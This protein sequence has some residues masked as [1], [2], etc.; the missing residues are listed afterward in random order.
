MKPCR[1]S[2][3]FFIVSS[4]TIAAAMLAIWLWVDQAWLGQAAN[5]ARKFLYLAGGLSASFL[6]ITWAVILLSKRMREEESTQTKFRTLLECVPDAL[7][8]MDREGHIVLVN[9]RTEEMFGYERAELLG[10]PA[11]TLVR[12]QVGNTS[13]ETSFSITSTQVRTS[14]PE[15]I[16]YHKDGKQIPLDMSFSPL[17]TEEGLLIINTVRDCSEQI[18]RDRRRATR[19]VIRRTLA[20]AANLA[21]A[22]PRLLEAMCENLEWD[23]GVLWSLDLESRQFRCVDCWQPLPRPDG[24]PQSP[25]PGEASSEGLALADRVLTSGQAIWISDSAEE[26]DLSEN[27]LVVRDNLHGALGIPITCSGEVIGV[28]EF[29][30]HQSREADEHQL[31][32]LRSIGSQI[33]QFMKHKQA[34]EAVHAS[35]ARKAAILEAAL[36]AIITIDHEGKIIELNPAAESMFGYARDQFI[37]VDMAELII[38][39]ERRVHFREALAKYLA[40]GCG[41]SLG[42]RLEMSALR[43]D[44]QEFPIELTVTGIRADGPPLFTSYI[45]DISERKQA[46]ETLRQTEERFRQAQKM[47]AIGRLA[48]GVAHDFNNLLTV[49]TGYSELLMA[50]LTESDPSLGLIQEI[51]KAA[52]RAAMLTRQLL[53][54]SRK[55]VLSSKVV[56]L[57]TI[58]AD[59]NKMLHRLIGEDVSLVPVLA[60]ELHPVKVDPGQVEQVVMNLAVNAR[61]AMPQGGMLTLETSNVTLDESY[62]REYPELQPGAFVLLA[63]SDTGCGM[64]EAVKARIFEPFFTTKEV[65][66]GTGLG[67]ATV[68]GIVKQ[69]G[70]HVSVYSEPGQGTTF[71]IYF[72]CAPQELPVI[73]PEVRSCPSSTSGT[74]TVLVVE[75]ED[76]VRALT[77]QVLQNDGYKVLE[78]RHGVEALEVCGEQEEPVHLVVTDVVMP[79]MNGPQLAELMRGMWPNLRV[80][81]LSG[82]TDRALLHSGLL[83]GN[84]NFLQKPFTPQDLASKVREMLST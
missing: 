25:T 4:A 50:S 9:R 39:P 40:T 69:A 57:N 44:G 71:K 42:K 24:E 18:N 47:E 36:D 17:Q 7:I 10:K 23:L 35:E 30:S 3:R 20:E 2:L 56:D 1:L 12:K 82:Y 31:E 22:A 65:G 76:G 19:Q 53:A 11:G 26:F 78:A 5:P 45:R 68:Y 75:D 54:F 63:V 72:P 80:L 43:A 37:G 64:D 62:T 84:H 58:L 15:A 74:E 79:K 38:P 55:Q 32:T 67:L 14:R 48:G 29:L 51:A 6:V 13:S 46:E 34:E 66:K 49:I 70:G 21:E 16:G 52:Q 81:F 83:D 41:P 27:P 59:M 77:K 28:L 61:D 60:P 8:I 73:R 33:G